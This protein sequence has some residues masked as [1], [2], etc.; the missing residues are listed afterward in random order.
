MPDLPSFSELVGILQSY[1]TVRCLDG[2]PPKGL[3]LRRCEFGGPQSN[4]DP[5]V[6]TERRE[7]EETG[8][9]DLDN[10]FGD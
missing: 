4:T 9:V 10:H 5:H 7:K 1:R 3:S 2:T 8:R 6:V